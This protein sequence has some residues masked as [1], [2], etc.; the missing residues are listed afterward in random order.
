[1]TEL[2]KKLEHPVQGADL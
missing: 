1:M 2:I